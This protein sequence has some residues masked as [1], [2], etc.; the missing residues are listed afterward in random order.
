MGVLVMMA[1]IYVGGADLHHLSWGAA[2]P[3]LAH[4]LLGGQLALCSFA[5]SLGGCGGRCGG[6]SGRRF[7]PVLDMLQLTFQV[8]SWSLTR[9]P[10]SLK[11]PVID[12]PCLLSL[13]DVYVVFVAGCLFFA[14]KECWS[15]LGWGLS[16]PKSLLGLLG[17]TLVVYW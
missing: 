10:W 13:V 2:D 7:L 16:L 5:S 8:I 1:V 11:E 6:C 17:P 3:L 4:G 14:K 15:V 9:S 12:Q